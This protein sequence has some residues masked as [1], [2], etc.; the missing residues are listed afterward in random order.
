[1]TPS[2]CF[3][4]ENAV[5]RS[6][7]NE[8][9]RHAASV[10]T[11]LIHDGHKTGPNQSEGSFS[12]LPLSLQPLLVGTCETGPPI[13]FPQRLGLVKALMSQPLDACLLRQRCG[14]APFLK[15]KQAKLPGPSSRAAR[16]SHLA[17]WAPRVGKKELPGTRSRREHSSSRRHLYFEDRPNTRTRGAVW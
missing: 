17:S 14:D 5:T 10:R 3:E 15:L 16:D 6:P 11:P 9:A 1:M 8:N 2:I 4:R 7:I 13:S 12:Q